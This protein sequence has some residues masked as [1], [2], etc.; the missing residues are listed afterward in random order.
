LENLDGCFDD[1]CLLAIIYLT[2]DEQIVE[3]SLRLLDVLP[4]NDHNFLPRWTTINNKD[5]PEHSLVRLAVVLELPAL[6]FWWKCY[7]DILNEAIMTEI[8]SESGGVDSET[9]VRVALEV[10]EVPQDRSVWVGPFEQLQG[11]GYS[12]LAAKRHGIYTRDICNYHARVR[13]KIV[14]LI[15]EQDATGQV[16]DQPALDNALAGFY[17]N[18]AIQRIVWASERLI[19]T[20]VGIYCGCGRD[21][22]EH[23]N[24]RNFSKLL[25]DANLRLAHLKLQDKNEMIQTAGMLAQFPDEEYKR[26]NKFDAK[27]ILAALRYDVNNRKHAI[28]GPSTRDRRT[29]R[30]VPPAE[31]LT[32][33]SKPQNV[34]MQYACEAFHQI[35]LSYKELMNWQPSASVRSVLR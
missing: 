12:L 18:A 27:F 19:K 16:Q 14:A 29:S 25:K 17:F 28:F 35:C 5:S 30:R 2:G 11:A 34:Q 32:W 33:S 23:F 13:S 9:A 10:L 15:L 31:A 1:L 4:I 21:P 20:F 3:D 22:E 24:S 26:E 7:G 8:P 6:R